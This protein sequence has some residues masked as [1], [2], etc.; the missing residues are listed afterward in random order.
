[1]RP[2]TGNVGATSPRAGAGAGGSI[3]G[4]NDPGAGPVTAIERSMFPRHTLEIQRKRFKVSNGKRA[5]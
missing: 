2:N 3:K 5:G 4:R 1:M